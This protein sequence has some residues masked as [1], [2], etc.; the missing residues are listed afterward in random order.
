[1]RLKNTLTEY[2]AISKIFHW[3]SAAV[4][5]FQIPLG[6]YLVDMDFSEKRLTVE[7]DDRDTLYNVIDLYNGVYKKIKIPIVFDY[8]HHKFNTGGISEEEALNIAI[9]TWNKITPVVHYSESR[10]LE[11]NDKKIKPQ[12][13]SD[14]IYNKINT[15]NYKLDIMIEA[16]K[17]ELAILDYLEKCA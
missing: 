14:F 5:I 10:N 11:K 12:A 6:F 7:N 15:Y 8:H 3:L 2:G 1:M 16:K 13:H 9:S 17:K 4:L